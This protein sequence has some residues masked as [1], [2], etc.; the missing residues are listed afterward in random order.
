MDL[1]PSASPRILIRSRRR[2]RLG[3][4][5]RRVN[6]CPLTLPDPV[7][8]HKI[9]LVPLRSTFPTDPIELMKQATTL[10]LISS[11]LP[12][13]TVFCAQAQVFIERDPVQLEYAI[14]L[15]QRPGPIGSA[16]VSFGPKTTPQGKR[17]EVRSLEKYTLP[18]STPLAIEENVLLVC[19]SKGVE[20]FE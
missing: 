13:F 6:K 12:F 10:V 5:P 16:V 15:D 9:N 3:P 14:F 20:S 1:L 7:S 19:D 8:W 2:H 11:I 4:A 17:L 18:A